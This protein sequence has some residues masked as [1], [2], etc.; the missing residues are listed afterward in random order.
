MGRGRRLLCSILLVVCLLLIGASHLV[1]R[2]SRKEADVRTAASEPRSSSLTSLD[3]PF[4][5][6]GSAFSAR[7][8]RLAPGMINPSSSP[9]ES[10]QKSGEAEL[11]RSA[12]EEGARQERALMAKTWG[13]S[14]EQYQAFE[15]ASTAAPHLERR[16]A[17][18]RFFRGEIDREK[19]D[20]EL[21]EADTLDT[22]PLREVLGT[23]YQE[24][25]LMRGHFAEAGLD[26]KPFEPP[27]ETPQ[28]P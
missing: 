10:D 20:K 2:N 17:Y 5:S 28:R 26:H 16:A 3:N 6:P 24:Y 18:D 8:P 19:F 15:A 27:I 1:G 12:R 23:H 21:R 25:E 13:M 4:S 14:D 9:K 7:G 22:K 11:T